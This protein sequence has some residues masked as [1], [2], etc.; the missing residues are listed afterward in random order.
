[1]F[2]NLEISNENVIKGAN[3]INHT[4]ALVH[5]VIFVFPSDFSFCSLFFIFLNEI[6]HV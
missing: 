2:H 4:S 5:L 1:M 6:K 3:V